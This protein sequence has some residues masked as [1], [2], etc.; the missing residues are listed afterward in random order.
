MSAFKKMPNEK[1]VRIFGYSVW[2]FVF[3]LAGVIGCLKKYG[4]PSS[5][6]LYHILTV[7]LITGVVF[8]ILTQIYHTRCQRCPDC[9]KS[10]R[11]AGED[12]HPTA[13]DRYLLYCERCDTIWD[14]TITF[15]ND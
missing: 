8:I 15:S 9:K 5:L 13:K 7:V 4:G 2:I 3:V 11:M 14:T 6:P 10:M 12:F 1:P